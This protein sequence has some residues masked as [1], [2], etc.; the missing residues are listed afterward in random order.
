VSATTG[1]KPR[2][3]YILLALADGDSHGQAIA[4]EVQGLS[5]GHVTLWPATL[6]SSLD[7]L[8]ATGWI[9]EVDDPRER[10]HDESERRRIFRLT[11]VGR[12]TLAAETDRLSQLV[13]VAR[14]RIAR[15]RSAS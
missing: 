15:T 13:R 2:H 10:R 7:D 6:Y 5:E 14:T 1:L 9:E 3:Y 12:R 11:A 4:R 8:Q